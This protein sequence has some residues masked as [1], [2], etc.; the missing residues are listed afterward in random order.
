MLTPRFQRL[1]ETRD[2]PDITKR[3]TSLSFI[4]RRLSRL[5]TS[6]RAIESS[7]DIRGHLGLN[8]LHK[9]SEPLIDFIFVCACSDRF[10]LLLER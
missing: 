10:E 4:E 3:S 7:E 9:S 6:R 5:T 2:Q 8:L 1:P